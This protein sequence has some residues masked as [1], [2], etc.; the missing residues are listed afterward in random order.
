MEQRPATGISCTNLVGTN[1][2]WGLI[3]FGFFTLQVYAAECLTILAGVS[4]NKAYQ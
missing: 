1:R 4:G 2:R 3:G